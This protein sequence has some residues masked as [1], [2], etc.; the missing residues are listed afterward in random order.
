MEMALPLLLGLLLL[1]YSRG[2]TTLFL[3][4]AC[5]ALTALIL[6]LSRGAWLGMATGLIF[7]TAC[8]LLDRHFHRKRLLIG[9]AGAAVFS[10]FIV[11]STT[12]VVERV[13]ET[14]GK[15]TESNLYC[16]I[17]GWKG[18]LDMIHEYPITGTGPGTY[19][20]TITQYQLP[21]LGKHRTMAHNDYLHFIAE[22]GLEMIAVIVISAIALFSKGFRKLRSESRLVRGTTLGA[23]TGIV[24]IMIHSFFDFNLHIPANA[25][26][27]A[28]VVGMTAAPLPSSRH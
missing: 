16:R 28:V 1:G 24:A 9:I 17:L 26:F 15:D 13:I 4:I 3:Y 6:S 25:I 23:L 11:L 2:E 7:M 22:T 12:P 20:Y 14:A 18:T 21:G 27:F 5:M 8:L 10:I 19:A